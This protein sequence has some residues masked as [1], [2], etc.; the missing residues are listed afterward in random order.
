MASI[1]LLEDEESVNRGVA[2]TLEKEGYTVYSA[3]TIEEAEGFLKGNSME[4]AICD[5]N[6][7]DGNSL[8]FVRKVRSGG[9][10]HIICLTALDGEFDQIAGYEAG[11]DDYITKPFSLSVLVLKVNAYF[12]RHKQKKE[13]L[14]RIQSGIWKFCLPEMKAESQGKEVSFTK[15]EWKLLRLFLEHP[16]Q[17][18]SRNQILEQ[19]FDADGE[20]VD[21]N[22]VAVNIRRL[23]EKIE[24]ETGKP[25]YI[26]NVRGLGYI[27]DKQC[28][29][30]QEAG[31]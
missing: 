13:A 1:L 6:L 16:K 20:F 3:H 10:A 26:R 29:K 11:A 9:S 5:I 12:D 4:M 15:T 17:I 19:I 21:E 7:P 23:R 18:L 28:V 25:E 2:F 30:G 22:T 14:D 27:W 8:D 24:P 31:K